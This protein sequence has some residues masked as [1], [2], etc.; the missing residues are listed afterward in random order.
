MRINSL[1][2]KAHLSAPACRQAGC[3]RT[4]LCDVASATP[5]RSF[6]RALHMSLFQKTV[7]W[8]IFIVLILATTQVWAIEYTGRAGRDPFSAKDA[9]DLL[10][11]EKNKMTMDVVLN[12]IVWST[13]QPRAIINKKMAKVG[14]KIGT[15]EVLEINR[16]SVKIN[17]NGDIQ[18][19]RSKS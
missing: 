8:N 5:P 9:S 15:I 19:L 2:K 13:T 7:C 3:F 17:N 12:G 11:A 18:I 14:T 4:P 10:L 6:R 1:L 16:D